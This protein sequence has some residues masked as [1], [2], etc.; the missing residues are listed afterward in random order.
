MA[1]IDLISKA[2]YA[3]AR[4]MMMF[5]E[6][7]GQH[8]AALGLTPA[9]VAAQA[10]DAD[11]YNYVVQS[12]GLM[13]T[14][15]KSWTAL[16]Q[17]LRRGD[18]NAEAHEFPAFVLPAAPPP[19]ARGVERRFRTLV[20]QVKASVHYDLVIGTELGIEAADHAAPDY[21]AI[22]PK[23]T[24]TI[25][26]DHVDIGWDWQGHRA[27]LDLCE[28]QVE[29][30]VG[31]GFGPLVHSTTPGY[32]DKTAFPAEPARWRYRAIYRVG[33]AQTG[34]WSNIVSVSVP[35]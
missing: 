35:P 9:Q 8:S 32:E 11:Y 16:K 27:F 17:S 25:N 18:V 12:H 30:G 10:A 1:K 4:Q 7:I 5:K 33:N 2:D 34:Q 14:H 29:R 3:F 6:N 22:R 24:A 21:T 28:I 19:V 13:Q 23:I 15:V 31:L 20:R 26:G